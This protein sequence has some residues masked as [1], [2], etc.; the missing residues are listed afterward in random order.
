[1]IPTL[2]CPEGLVEKPPGGDKLKTAI[3]LDQGGSRRVDP[4]LPALAAC[5][6]AVGAKAT[7]ASRV[8]RSNPNGHGA[9]RGQ[10]RQTR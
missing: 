2:Q 5:Q 1:M 3:R 8:K 4:V 6:R 7:A 10:R 9:R